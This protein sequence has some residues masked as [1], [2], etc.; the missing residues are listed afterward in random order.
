MDD[1]HQTATSALCA[2]ALVQAAH[3]A[4]DNPAFLV[5]WD[6]GRIVA[7]N[8]AVERVFGFAPAE[9]RNRSTQLLYHGEGAFSALRAR[10]EPHP[11]STSFHCYHTMQRRDGT[12]FPTEIL[13][14]LIL[15][16]EE[17]PYAA[18]CMVRDLSEAAPSLGPEDSARDFRVLAG[19]LPVAIYQRV[20][21]AE[22]HDRFTYLTGDLLRRYGVDIDAATTDAQVLFDMIEPTDREA[23]EVEIRWSWA[24]LSPID[25]QLRCRAPNGDRI[26]LR[27][28]SQP[29]RGRDGATIWDGVALDITREKNAEEQAHYLSLHDQLTGL[30]N[31]FQFLLNLTES[32]RA[33]SRN[34]QRLA[35]A[36]V[37][38]DGLLSINESHGFAA[39]DEL[40]YQVAGRLREHLQPGEHAGRAH[41][42]MFLVMLMVAPDDPHVRGTVRRI[43]SV[44]HE[45]F[46]LADGT[47]LT[48][49]ARMGIASYPDDAA[50]AD[51]LIR[52]SNVAID[53]AHYRR[54]TM[55]E[56]Y[57]PAL[58]RQLISRSR[59]DH[60]LRM[61]IEQERI[62]PHFQRMVR[63]ADGALLGLETLARIEDTDGDEMS[64]S[65]FIRLA[66]ESGRISRLGKLIFQRVAEQV[67]R[68]EA[69]GF[70]VPPLMVN[71]SAAQFRDPEFVASYRH[72][73]LNAGIERGIVHLEITES[74]LL[75]DLASTQETMNQLSR[76]GVQFA[77][78][79]FGTGFSSLR[80]LAHLPFDTL[81]IDRSFVSAIERDAR[82]RSIIE[83]LIRMG[84]VLGLQVIAEGVENAAQADWLR[85]NGC[86]G[87]QGHLYG[88][89][90]SGDDIRW[91]LRHR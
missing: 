48:I 7:A 90:A 47:R 38:I 63:L 43:E 68:W 78:D 30:P 73:V 14:Q 59:R 74:A 85:D 75:D 60:A 54:D 84:S 12:A 23:V 82:Q 1:S 13:V 50:D 72:N 65:E 71:C 35:I 89:P 79:D 70:R 46:E 62:V 45:P 58:S 27:V 33:A 91:A 34:D 10:C 17:R 56:F 21:D 24:S 77:I 31:R 88:R 40:L 39:G 67:K 5:D 66:E 41:G 26:W 51:G 8:N 9:L 37:D 52:A 87:A 28:M 61:A 76:L 4:G 53:R 16:A 86:H 2:D 44:F 49:G 22:G 81:K 55:H 3:L 20:R 29:R 69:D 6:T 83:A 36:H 32:I 19:H 15:D 11:G 64:P 80:Y 42:D 18:L 25:L 57:S